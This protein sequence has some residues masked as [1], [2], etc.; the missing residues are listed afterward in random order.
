MS[1][2]T[3]AKPQKNREEDWDSLIKRID[4][5]SKGVHD[6]SNHIEALEWEGTTK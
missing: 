4:D 3:E 2:E 1:T 6:L 5:L